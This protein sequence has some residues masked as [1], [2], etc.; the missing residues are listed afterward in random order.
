MLERLLLKD[1]KN[2]TDPVVRNRYANTAGII[3]IITNLLLGASKLLIGYL[4]HSI[5]IMAD[6]A[7]NISD[8]ASNCLTIAGFKLSSKAPDAQHPYGFARYEY[9]FGFAI[10]L[11]MLVMGC[12]FAKESVQKIFNPQDINLGISVYIT[13]IIAIAV[14]L[15][16]TALY[17]DYGKKISSLALQASATESRNDIISTAGILV[18]MLVLQYFGLN[19]DGFVGFAIS[20]FVI[21]SSIETIKEELEPIIGIKPTAEQVK[22]I[23]TKLLS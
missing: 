3:G 21:I 7:N 5:S 19:I 2:T 6:A 13:L 14:K 1:Y 9:V 15:F 22:L 10:G 11:L 20:I 4:S 12:L 18:A 23:S 17:G 8:C 16:Q